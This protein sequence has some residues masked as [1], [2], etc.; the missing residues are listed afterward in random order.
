MVLSSADDL[1]EVT[2]SRLCGIITGVLVFNDV[3]T[4]VFQT[5]GSE[6]V[7]RRMFYRHL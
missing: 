2:V 6:Q 5:T 1:L 4:V 7:C 3:A